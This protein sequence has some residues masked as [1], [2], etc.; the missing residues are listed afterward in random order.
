MANTKPLVQIA[1]FCEMVLVERDDVVSAIRI[2]DTYHVNTD[3]TGAVPEGVTPVIEVN[4][5]ISLKSGDLKGNYR[6][7]LV[8]EN[9]LGVRTELSPAGGWPVTFDGEAHGPNIRLKFPLGVRNLGLC[10]FDVMF[11]NEVLTRMPLR[12]SSAPKPEDLAK[13]PS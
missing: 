13:D 12:L 2:V 11:E 8:M 6:V 4:G 1:C 3:Q 10:W 9:P 5:L 7:S